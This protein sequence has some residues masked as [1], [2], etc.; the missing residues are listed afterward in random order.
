MEELVAF[1]EG[2]GDN[3]PQTSSRAAKRLRRKQKKVQCNECIL[4]PSIVKIP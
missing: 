1:I 3:E 4:P 2:D